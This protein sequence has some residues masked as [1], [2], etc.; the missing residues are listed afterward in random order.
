MKKN[1]I[2]I[3]PIFVGLILFN[4][5]YAAWREGRRIDPAKGWTPVAIP[6]SRPTLTPTPGWWATLPA[7]PSFPGISTT[8]AKFHLTTTPT[9]SGTLTQ[10][11][12]N[13]K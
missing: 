5:G 10:T 11:G 4:L 7:R 6:T 13:T 8:G 2:L 12:I 9:P 1:L 3:A